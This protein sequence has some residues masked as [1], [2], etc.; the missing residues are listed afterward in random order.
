[1]P[2]ALTWRSYVYTYPPGVVAANPQWFLRTASQTRTLPS[3][4]I[5]LSSAFPTNYTVVLD[6]H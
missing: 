5:V 1:M 3:A 6:L 2:Y 4:T